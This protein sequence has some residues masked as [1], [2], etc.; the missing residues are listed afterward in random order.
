MPWDTLEITDSENITA[1]DVKKAYAKKLKVTRPD[2][3]PE[4]FQKLR[5][6]YDQA[7]DIL[8]YREYDAEDDSD[9]TLEARFSPETDDFSAE[10]FEKVETERLEK[11]S[12][13]Q[14]EIS[15]I[16]DSILLDLKSNNLAS[17]QVNL[18][19]SAEYV[20]VHPG[21]L[22]AWAQKICSSLSPADFLKLEFSDELLC[23]EI[24]SDSNSVAI[25]CTD[26]WYDS[27]DLGRLSQ[28]CRFISNNPEISVSS[29]TGFIC[30]RL[31]CMIAIYDVD[32][33]ARL[34]SIATNQ[35]AAQSYFGDLESESRVY[36]GQIFREL[37]AKERIFWHRAIKEEITAEEWKA[38]DINERFKILNAKAHI[39]ADNVR[40]VRSFV[41][42]Q[43]QLNV[44][45]L[46]KHNAPP[47]TI[48]MSSYVDSSQRASAYEDSPSRSYTNLNNPFEIQSVER[49]K[50]I[51]HKE[52][53]GSNW[54]LLFGIFLLFKVFIFA[55]KDCSGGN[56]RDYRQEIETIKFREKIKED[57]RLQNETIQEYI[58][59]MQKSDRP[60]R[61][62]P[63]SF[64]LDS[65][66]DDQP[67]PLRPPEPDESTPL[68]PDKRFSID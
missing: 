11:I 31:A 30:E 41:P 65:L 13:E 58:K 2:R 57:N 14:P 44:R 54:W 46:F 55:S 12:R 66:P 3:D 49:P 53:S 23:Y 25:A 67:S 48:S 28:F 4:G 8:R 1:R 39:T 42:D 56:K 68:I 20:Y 36:L 45:V 22:D 19:R 63:K 34:S 17:A 52:G 35:M 27:Q 33:A 47:P 10:Y 60:I 18:E 6:A 38:P 40:I 24:Q 29:E 32:T 16:I 50:P 37:P 9:Q 7:Q 62:D 43:H 64:K 26:A 5:E 15:L 21:A 61:I 51:V 59:R